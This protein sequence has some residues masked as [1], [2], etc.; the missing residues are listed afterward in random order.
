MADLR[1]LLQQAAGEPPATLPLADIRR[2]GNTLNRR[3]RLVTNVAIALAATLIGAAIASYHPGTNT[4]STP[5]PTPTPV[6]TP[7]PIPAGIY[8]D[9][10]LSPRITFTVPD[11]PPWRT[12][13]TTSTSLILAN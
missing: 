9:P 12:S 6:V 7:G 4:P 8:T 3:R 10:A 5:Q 2:R 1:E 11:G 13:L